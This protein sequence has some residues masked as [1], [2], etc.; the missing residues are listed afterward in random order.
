VLSQAVVQVADAAPIQSLAQEL[1]YATVVAL[2]HHQQKM[3]YLKQSKKTFKIN[4]N[5]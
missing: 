5:L 2:K 1:P 3:E 4:T